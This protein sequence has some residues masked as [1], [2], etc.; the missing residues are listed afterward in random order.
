MLQFLFLLHCWFYFHNWLERFILPLMLIFKYL[1]ATGALQCLLYWTTWWE[2][3]CSVGSG[4]WSPPAIYISTQTRMLSIFL[5]LVS[6]Y[7]FYNYFFH[8]KTTRYHRSHTRKDC[9]LDSCIKW[10]YVFGTVSYWT[11]P[12]LRWLF[13]LWIW[14]RNDFRHMEAVLLTC[15]VIIVQWFLFPVS[16]L[17]VHY[18]D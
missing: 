15:R 8:Y 4:G 18:G 11:M 16:K 10:S 9:F 3:V 6:H 5:L 1:L 12:P 17:N 13:F 7:N 14:I 2:T